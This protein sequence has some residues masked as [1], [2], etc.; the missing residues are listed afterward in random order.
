MLFNYGYLTLNSFRV[1]PDVLKTVHLLHF[2]K[3]VN[4]RISELKIIKRSNN[5]LF[6]T[7]QHKYLFV[8]L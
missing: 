8:L 7:F 3:T 5:Y 1:K 4:F 2:I 6:S